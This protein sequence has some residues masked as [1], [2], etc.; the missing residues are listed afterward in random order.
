MAMVHRTPISAEQQQKQIA[1]TEQK[2]AL[3]EIRNEIKSETNQRSNNDAEINHNLNALQDIVTAEINLRAS[4]TAILSAD[5]QTEIQQRDSTI[6]NLNSALN[7]E[8]LN[9]ENADANILNDFN[10]AL[11][12]EKTERAESVRDA[13]SAVLV[14][15]GNDKAAE[16]IENEQLRQQIEAEAANQAAGLTALTNRVETEEGT[17]AAEDTKLSNAIADEAAARKNADLQLQNTFNTAISTETNA[18]VACDT[19]LSTALTNA[20]NTEIQARNDAIDSASKIT[21]AYVDQ[22]VAAVEGNLNVFTAPT[23]TQ[24]GKSGIVP[25]T[26]AGMFDGILTTRGWRTPE[27]A[28][29]TISVL[30]TQTGTLTYTSNTTQTPTWTNFDN[31]KLKIEGELSGVDAKTYTVRFTPIDMYMW[32]DTLDQQPKTATWVIQPCLLTKPS[33]S[34]R[35]FTFAAN[36]TH[37]LNVSNFDAVYE[38]QTGTISA[39]NVD[40]YTAI[41]KLRSP[42]NTRWNDGSVADVEIS[43][44]IKPLKLPKPSAAV[45]E[46][47]C[48]ENVKNLDVAN[49]NSTYIRKKS[50]T[51]SES[52]PGNYSVVY[53]LIDKAN[54]Q[55]SDSTT[56]DVTINW[57]INLRVLT[58]EQSSGFAQVGTLTYNG[59]SQSVT[60][61]N[62]DAKYHVLGSDTAKVDAGTYTVTVTPRVGCV[63]NDMTKTAKTVSWTIQPKTLAIPYADV[64]AF[65][66][67]GAAKTLQ[68]KNYDPATMTQDGTVSTAE[69]G[70]Y[71]VKYI[72]KS[73]SNYKWADNSVT[74]KVIEWNVGSKELPKPS[75]ATTQ[76]T[77]SGDTKT[78]TVL[79][80]DTNYMTETGTK[81]EVNAGEYQVVYHLTNTLRAKWTDGSVADVVITWK[82]DRKKLTATQSNISKTGDF[83]YNKQ[84][85]Y[86]KNNLTN[87]DENYHDL[88]SDTAKT[89]SGDYTVKVAPKSNYCWSSGTFEE[90]T[91]NWKINVLKLEKPSAAVTVFEWDG[92]SK[93]LTISNFDNNYESQTGTTSATNVNSY[94]VTYKLRNK[95]SCTWTDNSTDDVVINW[96]IDRQKLSAENS[97]FAQADALTYTGSTYYIKDH[98]TGYNSTYHDL[99]SDTSKSAA[100][101]YTVKITPKSTYAFSDGTYE[102]REVQW[103]IQPLSVDMPVAD[104]TDFVYDGKSHAPT[105]TGFNSSY[106]TRSGDY[107]NKTALGNYKI[108]Y[109]LKN[110]TNTR[111]ADGSVEPY[112]INWSIGLTKVEFPYLVQNEFV[113]D[114]TEHTAVLANFDSDTMVISTTASDIM[115]ATDAFEQYCFYVTLKDTTKNV[116]EDGSNSKYPVYWTIKRKPLTAA[117]STG[118]AQSG[119]LNYNGSNQT[120]SITNFDANYH[121]LS[122]QYISANAGTFVAKITPRYN[123]C[124]N[125]GSSQAI[126]VVWTID[127]LKLVKPSASGTTDFEYDKQAHSLSVQNFNDTYMTQSGDATTQ[128]NTGFYNTVYSL[129]S[130]TNT[131]WDDDSVADVPVSWSIS[132]KQIPKPFWDPQNSKLRDNANKN[133]AAWN[134]NPAQ[135]NHIPRVSSENRWYAAIKNYDA[136]KMSFSATTPASYTDDAPTGDKLYF[137]GIG[138][139]TLKYHLTSDLV[140]WEGG[141]TSDFT[142]TLEIIPAV[143]SAEYS[144][145]YQKTIPVYSGVIRRVTDSQFTSGVFTQRQT[146]SGET[147]SYNAGEYTAYVEPDENYTWQDGTRTKK[148][149]KWQIAPAQIDKPTLDSSVT[150]TYDGNSKSP[151]LSGYDSAKMT[152]GSDTSATNAGVYTIT[153][154]PTANYCWAEDGSRDPVEIQWQIDYQVLPTLIWN[155]DPSRYVRYSGSMEV[156]PTFDGT[157]IYIFESDNSKLAARVK[158]Y[159]S[160]TMTISGTFSASETGKTYLITF[161]PKNANHSFNAKRKQNGIL[162]WS[163]LPATLNV[164]TLKSNGILSYTGEAQSPFNSTINTNLIT[165]TGDATG[166]AK[167]SYST[168]L[169]LKYPAHTQ[170]LL[171]DN[172]KTTENQFYRWSIGVTA[173]GSTPTLAQDYFDYG[174]TK[175]VTINGFDSSTMTKTGTE[176]ASARGFYT[177]TFKLKDTTGT[178]WSTGGSSDIVKEWAIGKKRIAKPTLASGAAT[179]FDYSGSAK[180][181]QIEGYDA[182]TMQMTGY[183]SATDAGSYTVSFTPR[184]DTGVTYVWQDGSSTAVNFTWKINRQALPDVT[185]KQQVTTSNLFY[186]GESQTV[187][188]TNFDAATMTISGDTAKIN[189]GT[190]TAKIT[191]KPNYCWSDSTYAAKS[192]SWII[193]PQKITQPTAIESFYEYTGSEVNLKYKFGVLTSDS[194]QSAVTRTNISATAPGSYTA[195]FS[196]NDKNNYCWKLASGTTTNNQTIS[197]SIGAAFYEVPT[198]SPTTQQFALPT[199][200][201]SVTP[202]DYDSNAISA[203]GLSKTFVH[204]DFNTSTNKATVSATFTLVNYP[205]AKWADGQSG[206]TRTVT[207]EVTAASIATGSFSSYAE[208]SAYLGAKYDGNSHFWYELN[209]TSDPTVTYDYNHNV[210]SASTPSYFKTISGTTSATN[211]GEYTVSL[212]PANWCYWSTGGRAAKTIKWAIEKAFYPIVLSQDSVTLNDDNLSATV[213]F[214]T[215]STG[216]VTVTSN[217]TS[218]ATVSYNS[219]TKVITINAGLSGTTSILVNQAADTNYNAAAAKTITVTVSRSL[220]SLSWAQINTL[221]K[222]DTLASQYRVG[223]CKVTPYF[224]ATIG[225]AQTSVWAFLYSIL[226]GVDHNSGIEGKGRAH[227]MNIIKMPNDTKERIFIESGYGTTSLDNYFNIYGTTASEAFPT[228]SSYNFSKIRSVCNQFLNAL[229]AELQNVIVAC[230]KFSHVNVSR[231][232]DHTPYSSTTDKIWIPSMREITGQSTGNSYVD[233]RVKQ[234][235]YFANGNSRTFYGFNSVSKANYWTRDQVDTDNNPNDTPYPADCYY[236]DVNGNPA[237]AQGKYSYGFLPCFTIGGE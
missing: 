65:E 1:A 120:V 89:E 47:D 157:T 149:V 188:I 119:T 115:S 190:Y 86:I 78:I 218:I 77:Y 159:D 186:N 230:K 194:Y 6:F 76:F 121:Q 27:D 176:S 24:N 183:L 222:N 187:T 229:P 32:S 180:T 100:G 59:N 129:K 169:A 112:V 156:A 91:F 171:S 123:Y 80:V 118:F 25:E 184:T 150:L 153:A 63:W 174:G 219:S 124:W 179:E 158:N 69:A 191:P 197:W 200:T 43:W 108:T 151:T 96:R 45:T 82:I 75:C 165:V 70:E 205:N 134:N 18:R 211:A 208:S 136:G 107:G 90:K 155:Q 182:N 3:D 109:T 5:L 14:A 4:E 62:F 79:N 72:L 105:V 143:L 144:E 56:A 39:S 64:T 103:T 226:I 97:T 232:T 147:S 214:T 216:A 7:Q 210:T 181:L 142:L 8:I 94:S 113:Y 141:D 54:T 117:Q 140:V 85:Q 213:D 215:K 10:S 101:T 145:P 198:I 23:A 104:N 60:V 37:G 102:A 237:L 88:T 84:I 66:Y 172:T 166:T 235:D 152:L 137:H 234:Y 52:E 201:Y 160:D 98:L 173:V 20:I 92:T 9:R 148:T 29:L 223:S 83:T 50:G 135:I 170:W 177:I 11:D 162:R 161:T 81:S 17:R 73:K 167:K 212:T 206:A 126:P 193:Y 49:L 48:D 231:Y 36:T 185:F 209:H 93:A 228:T 13:I 133:L 68:V 22:Q 154:T 87:I 44:E 114:G 233:A 2:I 28:S 46:F 189:A 55:W 163:I 19:A 38:S 110:T 67:D 122:G 164:P 12:Q 40:S 99:S 199:V 53:E 74:D 71:S 196:L 41:Y 16:A 217:D 30:P 138:T 204:T 34:V 175:T 139:Y 57:K 51:T 221:A 35:E 130:T 236:I 31:K 26:P 33:A 202:S 131:T 125:N 192:V 128:T 127:P 106:M 227:F 178:C 203:T 146:W 224:E 220:N 195:T 21:K 95:T 61:Q 207:W 168:T 111:W 225:N 116:W 42:A 58:L 132:K 15:M